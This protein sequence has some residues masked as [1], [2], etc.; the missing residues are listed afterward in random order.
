VSSARKKSQVKIQSLV[1]PWGRWY[2]SGS[3]EFGSMVVKPFLRQ[4][5]VEQLFRTQGS[6]SAALPHALFKLFEH[7]IVACR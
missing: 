3:Q 4:R 1:A 2:R 7:G 5:R 6:S